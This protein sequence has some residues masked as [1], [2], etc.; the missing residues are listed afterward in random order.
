MD[1]FFISFIIDNPEFYKIINEYII[2]TDFEND[3]DQLIYRFIQLLY[4]KHKTVPTRE[5]LKRVIN[6][7]LKTDNDISKI[8]K[9][10]QTINFQIDPRDSAIVR[11]NIKDFVKRKIYERLYSEDAI[12]AA[13]KG[14]FDRIDMIVEEAKKID[15]VDDE[16]VD[17]FSDENI[18]EIFEDEKVEHL[19]CGITALDVY[20]HNGGPV[21][22]EVFCWLAPTGR[23]KSILMANGGALLVSRG[24]DVLHIS[25]E[26]SI[27]DNS[28][29]YA[30]IFTDMNVN[31]RFDRSYK[32]KFM[33]ILN[34]KKNDEKRGDLYIIEYPPDEINI[35]VIENLLQ[36]L[37][38]SKNWKPDVI[39]I[40]YLEL[41]K[42]RISSYNEI[43]NDYIK[44]KMISTELHSLAVRYDV[45]VI[46][47]SQ[48]NRSGY[49]GLRNDM[50]IDLSHQAE[51]FGKAMPMNYMV[52]INQTD[53]Q[54]QAQPSVMDFYIAKN[55]HGPTGKT[56]TA[57]VNYGSFKVKPQ[58][59]I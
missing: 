50:K 10:Y 11:D 52:S 33:T 55:R 18:K 7:K 26:M 56:V 20:L 28:V 39:I 44:Q 35:T 43:G 17:Y 6:D 5:T 9:I 48:T 49:A 8:E 23:G 38:I 45:L 59:Q 42:S 51:S 40:D 31:Y 19:T 37:R 36:K 2:P 24:Y 34:E 1:K 47:A 29:R 46:T 14:D 30:G 57:V 54:K 27:R 16:C 21:R 13:S 22:G 12:R 3:I 32:D 4:K 53:E 15:V 58:T 41:M 25:L